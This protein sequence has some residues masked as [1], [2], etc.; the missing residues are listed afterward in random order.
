MSQQINLLNPALIKQ[1]DLL[2]PI[3]ITITLALL[4]ILMLSYYSL[5]KKELSALMAERSQVAGDL[6]AAQEQLKQSALMHTPREPNKALIDHITQLE[7][8][9]SMQQQVL[10]IVNLSSAT[11]EKGYAALMRSF[12]KQSVDGLWLTSFNIDSK[13]EQLN[14]SGR[15][16]QADLVPEYISR[17]GNEAALKG[18][19]F[20]ALNMSASKVDTSTIN[21]PATPS[22]NLSTF[23]APNKPL[24]VAAP[25]Q[26]SK[27]AVPSPSA[28]PLEPQYIEFT[29]QALQSSDDKPASGAIKDG[30]KS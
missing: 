7:Q 16:L 17:L 23:N 21:K 1:K 4:L 30:G 9:E 25:A 20:S 24:S 11:P 29:L 22:S 13:T 12:A 3:N 15:A 8:K 26:N 28:V 2:N 27:I 19:L 6:S 10:Q 5:E 14:I 18:K